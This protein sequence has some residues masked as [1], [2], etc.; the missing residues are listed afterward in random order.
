MSWEQSWGRGCGLSG[1]PIACLV[2]RWPAVTAGD[3]I[4]VASSRVAGQGGHV[5][6]AATAAVTTGRSAAEEGH[7]GMHFHGGSGSAPRQDAPGER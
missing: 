5:D 4:R 3:Q 7:L 2:S 1:P 6:G